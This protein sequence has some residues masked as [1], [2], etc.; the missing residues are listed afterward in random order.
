VNVRR[1]VNVP[2][3]SM[4]EGNGLLPLND[5]A[6]MWM[7]RRLSFIFWVRR[8]GFEE[9]GLNGGLTTLSESGGPL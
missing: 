6:G 4:L 2:F 7:R 5:C 8:R 1:V 9:R 3:L